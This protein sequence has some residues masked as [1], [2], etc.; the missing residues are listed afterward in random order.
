MKSYYR[1]IFDR[2]PDTPNGDCQFVELEDPW[3]NSVKGVWRDQDV[4]VELCIPL[5]PENIII[6]DQDY[7]EVGE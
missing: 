6:A 7:L 5:V 1:V 4:W 3:G 2:M